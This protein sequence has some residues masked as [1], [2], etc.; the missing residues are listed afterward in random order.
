MDYQQKEALKQKAA[1]VGISVI[2]GGVAW[3]IVLANFLG[4][5]SPTTAQQRTS[6][7]VTA[8]VEQVLAPF[9]AD[10]F[11]ANKAALAKFTKSSTDYDRSEVV[12][13]TVP[14]L[15]TTTVDYRLADRC[16]GVIAARL[17]A[18]SPHV[19]QDSSKKS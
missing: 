3:W 1:V 10:S 9:C 17:K 6:D 2:A 14:K 19:A 13:N 7:A 16:A 8:K 18:S 5:V 12:Q 15:G 4:W 11:M